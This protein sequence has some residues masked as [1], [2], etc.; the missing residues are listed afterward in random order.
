MVIEYD[1]GTLTTEEML[2]F[3]VWLS[4][5]S[6]ATAVEPELATQCADKF[7]EHFKERFRKREENNL[8]KFNN[9]LDA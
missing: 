7:L 4:V 1:E 2:W 3:E 9:T 6:R 8:R 5:I